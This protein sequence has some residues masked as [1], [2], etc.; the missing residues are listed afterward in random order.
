MKL[1]LNDNKVRFSEINN[2]EDGKELIKSLPQDGFDELVSTGMTSVMT[3]DQWFDYLV[4]LGIKF[5]SEKPEI[6]PFT[7]WLDNDN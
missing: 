5:D 4:E 1:E 2:Y 7:E 3:G 6:D